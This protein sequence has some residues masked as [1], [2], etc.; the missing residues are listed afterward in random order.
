MGDVEETKRIWCEEKESS[1]THVKMLAINV[2]K[3]FSMSN[4]LKSTS[5]SRDFGCRDR[6]LLSKM[7]GDK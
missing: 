6:G 1:Y 5:R 3:L 4:T 2:A 7:R